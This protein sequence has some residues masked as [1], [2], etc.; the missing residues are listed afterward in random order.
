MKF[1]KTVQDSIYSPQF[2]SAILTKSFKSSLGYFLLL[3]LFLTVIN[4]LTLIKPVF[5]EAPLAIQSFA[6]TMINCYPKNLEIKI[7]NG[8]VSTNV[9]EPYFISSCEGN[10]SKDLMVLDTKTPFSAAQFES[11]QVSTWVTKD[12]IVYKKND[13]ET[14]TYNLNK[15]KDFKLNKE[16]INSYYQM[17]SPYLKFAGPILIFLAFVGIFLSYDFRLLYLLLISSLIWLLGKILKYNLV[18]GQSYKLGLH[19]IT[20]GLIVELVAGL[21]QPW[22][23]FAGFPF[24]VSILTLA[25]VF[26][27]LILPKK[28][29]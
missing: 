5:I 4:L 25:V 14:N 16:L 21:I 27:N 20:L 23:H 7:S 9:S 19:A 17:F 3:I 28:T 8:Q 13:I 26:V 12:A 1:F 10:K 6:Q 11:Y 24:M 15:I 22:T 18:Y 29:S 2:Y